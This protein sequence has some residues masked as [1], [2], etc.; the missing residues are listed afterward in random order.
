M[1]RE[2]SFSASGNLFVPVL[3]NNVPLEA[4]V[5]TAAQVTV[6][7]KNL[8]KKIIPCLKSNKKVALRGINV[9]HPIIARYCEG[10]DITLGKHTY[11]WNV[12]VAPIKD[13]CILGLDFITKHHLDIKLSNNI[14]EIGDECIPMHI[15]TECKMDSYCVKSVVLDKKTVIRP[16]MGI[17]LPLTVNYDLLNGDD[18]YMFEPI[19]HPTLE[20]ISGVFQS[21]NSLP[22]VLLNHSNRKI[23]LPAGYELGVMVDVSDPDYARFVGTQPLP[24]VEIRQLDA[25]E[26]PD[27]YPA[28]KSPHFSMIR[29]TL[30][31]HLHDL[32]YRS[33]KH[34]TFYQSIE[35]ANLLSQ[36]ACT[37]SRGDTD[38]G[39]FTAVVHRI[40]LKSDR[41]I[42][43]QMRRTPLHFEGEEEG[44]LIRLK[45]SEVIS[46]S[47]SEYAH[48]VC[49]VRKKDGSIRYCIDYRKLNDITVKDAFPIPKIHQCIDTLCGSKY[50]G[51]LDLAQGYYQI[52]IAEEDKHKTAFI[53]KYGLFQHERMPFGLC[54]APAT[55]QRAM[56]LVLRGLLFKTCLCYIDDVIICAKT[57]EEGIHNIREVLERFRHYNLKL[58]PKKCAFFQ[59]KLRYLGRLISP[60]GITISEEHVKCIRDYPVP[61]TKKSLESFLGFINYHRAFIRNYAEV[62]DGL[63]K[64][65]STSAYGPIQLSDSHLACIEKIRADLL[66]APTFPYPDP[67][68][69]FILDCD[70]SDVGI[71]CELS[72]L[73]GSQE[74]VV[75]YGSYALTPAQRRYCT[76]RKELLAIVRFTRLYRHYLLGRTFICRTDHNSLTWLMSFKNLEGQLARWMEE[77]SQYDMKIIH[78]P[79]NQHLNADFLSRIPDGSEFCPNYRTGVPLS[80]LPC[81]QDGKP[82]SFCKRT[83]EKWSHFEEDVDYVVP[84][85]VRS[86]S[87][88]SSDKQFDPHTTL[89][90]WF[91]KHS[92]EE[93]ALAQRDDGDLRTIILWLEQNIEPTQAVLALSSPAI[94]HYWLA[95]PQLQL[96]QSVLYYVWND[97]SLVK[98]KLVV[99]V[100]LRDEVLRLCHDITS[101]AHPGQQ[102]TYLRVKSSFYWHGMRSDCVVFV[103]T[104]ATCNRNK[105][106]KQH[107][108]SALGEYHVGAPMDRVMIDI[109]GPLTKTPRGNTVVLMMIDQFTKWVEC[110]PLPNQTIDL[111]AKTVV[112][113]FFARFGCPLEIHTDQGSNFMSGVFVDLANLLQITKTRTTAYRPRS[114]GN[115]E[116]IN[117][118]LLQMIRCVSQ[119]S[120][121]NWDLYIPQL[122]GAIRSSVNRST[123]FTPNQLMLGREV[124][125]PVD[126]VFGIGDENQ[127]ELT[128][129]N[130]VARLGQVMRSCH[131]AARFSLQSAV[132]INKRDYDLKMY[133]RSYERGDLVYLTNPQIKTGVSKKLQSI[134]CGPYLVV[135][136]LSSVLYRIRDR[137]GDKVVHHDRLRIC[138]DRHIP[139]WMRKMRHQ[140]LQ[141]DETIAYDIA[142]SDD[143][144][145]VEPESAVA[146]LFASSDSENKVDTEGG[147]RSLL[148]NSDDGLHLPP[149]ENM[150]N[151]SDQEDAN[152]EDEPDVIRH[153]SAVPQSQTT[154]VGR[155]VRPSPWL[156]DYITD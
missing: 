98:Y 70:A 116:R 77:I 147:N 14:L 120:T 148:V 18:C 60:D 26:Y 82:C 89:G 19:E 108:R 110:V 59:V 78:R 50:F 134:Y 58:K 119:R 129:E 45:D 13:A 133:Q 1:G 124:L 66:A 15:S 154:R 25:E 156:R 135:E 44:H 54:N 68:Y 31:D 4:V 57:F 11:K 115:I 142:E 52:E 46:E 9:D 29:D 114:N 105:K 17:M 121:K 109:L 36:F 137:R 103:R 123:G 145:L 87:V 93:I 30:P 117:R 16:R 130:Y 41:A 96:R 141:L 51:V 74:R 80:D 7:N 75:A 127:E 67:Q 90:L 136:V 69:T 5:D 56:Q 126:L 132:A 33:C 88:N 97:G 95:R 42:R 144:D 106:P 104:C 91:P 149:D 101:A 64:V 24:T 22:M 146:D 63:Y 122:C 107:R 111:V 34:I 128:P 48:P 79:G 86:I 125:K 62:T 6:I 27:S 81:Y 39:R 23:I 153:T 49:L 92:V 155:V 37:F 65:V 118:T 139:L 8:A 40:I 131:Q 140:F 84:L 73:V 152:L 32:F 71:G 138:N 61:R 94:R 99:P 12:F 10:V 2:A 35:L 53:T 83:H 3:I 143:P 47:N 150:E 28:R 20:I 100:S 72:Q 76:T 55:F 102:N 151:D 113:E 21:G 38:L 112:D 85:A 43:Q